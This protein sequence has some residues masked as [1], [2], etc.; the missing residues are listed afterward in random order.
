MTD[1]PHDTGNRGIMTAE[2]G[3]RTYTEQEWEEFSALQQAGWD[4]EDRQLRADAAA[5]N[6]RFAALPAEEQQEEAE[7]RGWS[8][9]IQRE[10]EADYNPEAGQ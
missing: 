3:D 7:R 4:A 5:E 9:A 8:L 6:A 1:Q 2:S 10:P